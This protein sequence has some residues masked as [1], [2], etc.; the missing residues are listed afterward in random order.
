MLAGVAGVAGVP[1]HKET[2]VML[3]TQRMGKRVPPVCSRTN[4]V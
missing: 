4:L 2:E 1:G 3:A